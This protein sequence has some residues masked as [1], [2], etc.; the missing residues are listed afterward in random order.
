MCKITNLNI[1]KE[2]HTILPENNRQLT[3]LFTLLNSEMENCLTPSSNIIHTVMSIQNALT[4]PP[5]PSWRLPPHQQDY[6]P[7]PH[8]I[9]SRSA[10]KSKPYRA[11]LKVTTRVI[12]REKF[13][14]TRERD[15]FAPR[16][17][18]DVGQLQFPITPIACSWIWLLMQSIGV[19]IDWCC[20]EKLC[21]KNAWFI[22]FTSMKF[23][24]KHE[25]HIEI[26]RR[27]LV[28]LCFTRPPT[29]LASLWMWLFQ[30]KTSTCEYSFAG[31]NLI[32][33][34]IL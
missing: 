10:T 26:P 3:T 9:H 2:L 30:T 15:S 24:G 7:S 34:K 27:Q 5:S 13:Y 8:F 21:F 31:Q 18:A 22:M 11:N 4:S 6:Q 17:A 33:C 12:S 14:M 23:G 29:S 25:G 28:V 32:F 20:A 1:K 16:T 19:S